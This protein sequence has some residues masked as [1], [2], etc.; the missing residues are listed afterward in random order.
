MSK[1][2]DQF[3]DSQTQFIEDG[4]EVIRKNLIILG[5]KLDLVGK[6]KN[7]NFCLVEFKI[8]TYGS[9]EYTGKRQLQRYGRRL[10]RIFET[11]GFPS[12]NFR[13]ILIRKT[14]NEIKRK[15]YF[16]DDIKDQYL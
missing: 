8:D 14:R 7:G 9:G 11:F 5:G 1:I 2:H 6:D 10:N 3:M 13:L 15:E 4:F 12:M 16:Y